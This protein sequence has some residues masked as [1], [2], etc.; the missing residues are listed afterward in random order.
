MK[1]GCN[2]QKRHEG[3]NVRVLEVIGIISLTTIVVVGALV[4]ISPDFKEDLNLKLLQLEGRIKGD[5]C[6]SIK[7]EI[8]VIVNKGFDDIEDDDYH[9]LNK[10]IHKMEALHCEDADLGRLGVKTLFFLHNLR[11]VIEGLK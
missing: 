3:I 6:D 8:L 1:I 4:F 7:A 2:A 9:E 10:Y 5:T 11:Q